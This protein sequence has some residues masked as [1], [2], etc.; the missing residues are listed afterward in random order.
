M[1]TVIRMFWEQAGMAVM[2]VG[3]CAGGGDAKQVVYSR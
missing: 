1:A 2:I 3:L